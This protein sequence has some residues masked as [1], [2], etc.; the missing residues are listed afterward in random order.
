MDETLKTAILAGANDDD[1][2]FII[3]QNILGGT[4]NAHVEDYF[5]LNQMTDKDIKRR[6]RFKRKDIERLVSIFRI[7]QKV[8]IGKGITVSGTTALCV[9]LRRLAY[10]G[11]LEDL[12]EIFGLSTQ[13]LSKIIH[14]IS[15]IIINNCGELLDN[16]DDLQWLNKRKLKYYAQAVQ[17]RGGAI[18]NCWGFIDG[19]ERQMSTPTKN[20]DDYY[21]YRR[22][23]HCLKFQSVL[24]PD[25]IIASLKGPYA[26]DKHNAGIF[27]LS[28]LYKQLEAKV[29]FDKQTFALYG[30]HYAL[31]TLVV[32]PYEGKPL[33]LTSRQRIFNQSMKYLR[34]GVE[35]GFQE[36]I[37]IFPFVDFRKNRKLSMQD[38]NSLYKV[39]T[40]LT[41]CHTCLYGS[42]TSTYFRT[43]PPT[44]NEYFGLH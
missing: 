21:S 27:R 2:E 13:N 33:S 41:N 25:G 19:I 44:L 36:V 29:I 7:P 8:E 24:C 12:C 14:T 22:E 23:C 20:P 17:A 26:A 9:L 10:H 37:A 32:T 30:E 43:T 34:A 39:A 16:L 35:W 42:R 28:S 4:K 31:M 38:L 18:S 3:L 15:T 5:N 6:F 11:G 40:L 1:I